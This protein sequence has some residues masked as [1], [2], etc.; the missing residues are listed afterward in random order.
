MKLLNDF[1]QIVSISPGEG[2]TL[3]VVRLNADHSI[4]QAHFPGNPV[5]PGVCLVQMATEM[6]ETVLHKHLLL[7]TA[8]R[9][10]FRK[11]IDPSVQPTFRFQKMQQLDGQVSVH[12]TI[13][14]AESQYAKM[15]LLYDC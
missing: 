4:Y 12:V 8:V 13:E 10:K 9:I 2:E 14:D 15:S 7:R 1:F 6:L 3:G 11:P 5:T